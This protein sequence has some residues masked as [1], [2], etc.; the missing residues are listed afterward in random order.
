MYLPKKDMFLDW[1]ESTV[2]GLGR[3]H[4]EIY[5][6]SISSERIHKMLE[7][8]VIGEAFSVFVLKYIPQTFIIKRVY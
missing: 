1:D 8:A 5:A 6:W 7:T 2:K 3:G 4:E